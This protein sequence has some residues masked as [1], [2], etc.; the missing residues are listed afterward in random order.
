MRDRLREIRTKIKM[1]LGLCCTKGCY[2][3]ATSIIEIREIN[4]KRTLCEKHRKNLEKVL[5]QA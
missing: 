3:K 4:V 2:H 5:K 1:N